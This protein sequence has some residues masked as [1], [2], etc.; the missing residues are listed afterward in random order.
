[1]PT[2][3]VLFAF[4]IYLCINTTCGVTNDNEYK[5]VNKVNTALASVQYYKNGELL[6]QPNWIKKACLN[7]FKIELDHML[8]LQNSRTNLWF[9]KAGSINPD[10]IQQH[11]P[12]MY[13]FYTSGE[14]LRWMEEITKHSIY[15]Q[16]HHHTIYIYVYDEEDDWIYW[17]YDTSWYEGN[18]YTLLLGL[19]N[20]GTYNQNTSHA[21]LQT[22]NGEE[23]AE[24]NHSLI[25]HPA[26]MVLFNGDKVYHR[27][28]PL[29]AGEKRI[30]L[31]MEFVDN[32]HCSRFSYIMQGIYNY[33]GYRGD[34]YYIY[35]IIG[36]L[37][38]IFAACFVVTTDYLV[39]KCC[40][41][42][43]HSTTRFIVAI[44][45]VCLSLQLTSIVSNV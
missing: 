12:K 26:D 32:I 4:I 13:Q 31:A 21:L 22:K 11:A 8:K 39:L 16:P 40:G 5:C 33:V 34:S 25:I 17:H 1:M 30:V 3:C 14:V 36:S 6:Y 43:M 9:R 38:A 42:E 2:I 44:M 23:T 24:I 41:K 20:E 35:G 37:C 19:I 27:V 10:V 18:R 29:K 45:G 15:N 7:S 28:T